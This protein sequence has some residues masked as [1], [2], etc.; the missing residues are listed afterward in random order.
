MFACQQ[1]RSAFSSYRSAASVTP[2]DM[3]ASPALSPVRKKLSSSQNLENGSP[4]TVDHV[5]VYHVPIEFSLLSIWNTQYISHNQ[6]H[7]TAVT[8]MLQ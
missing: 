3:A 5:S 8:E 1:Q 4:S 2:S 6:I 7:S